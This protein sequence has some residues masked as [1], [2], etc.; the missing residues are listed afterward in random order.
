MKKNQEII[1]DRLNSSL[2]HKKIINFLNKNY[3]LVF[4]QVK[5]NEFIN[6]KHFKKIIFKKKLF[7]KSIVFVAKIDEKI[8]GTISIYVDPISL[9]I[10]IEQ[11]VSL[12]PFRNQKI[13]ICEIGRYA[14]DI[15]HR[16]NPLITLLLFMNVFDY[17]I[18]KKIYCIVA[19]GFNHT[20]GM[21]HRF[22][23]KNFYGNGV[24]FKDKEFGITC[25]PLYLDVKQKI[26]DILIRYHSQHFFTS[27]IDIKKFKK[28][29][30]KYNC[31]K[32]ISDIAE[33]CKI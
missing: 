9:P 10:E 21:L 23:M 27:Q 15:N 19:Q 25:Y 17:C 24:G 5:K 12:N 3:K 29:I 30:L 26:E 8:V 18:S 14:I 20:L 7:D 32:L 22:G 31:N 1:I 2:D 13:K 6:K 16:F 33:Q 11:P 4:Y 28:F